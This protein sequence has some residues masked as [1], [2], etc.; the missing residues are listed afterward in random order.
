MQRRTPTRIGTLS[1]VFEA[2]PHGKRSATERKRTVAGQAERSRPRKR[3]DRRRARGPRCGAPAFMSRKAASPFDASV[4][5]NRKAGSPA[6]RKPSRFG[7]KP[8]RFG[9]K[10]SRLVRKA[11]RLFRKALRGC[12]VPAGPAADRPSVQAQAPW[13]PVRRTRGSGR[14]RANQRC[15]VAAARASRHAAQAMARRTRRRRLIS[16][17]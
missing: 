12:A 5:P 8:S 3:S 2:F 11:A 4:S 10:A 6:D 16:T 15:T 17:R 13:P 1:R 9:R 7:R 14:Q